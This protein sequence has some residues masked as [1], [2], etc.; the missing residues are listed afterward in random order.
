MPD[1]NEAPLE[2]RSELSRNLTAFDIT[3]VGVGAMIGAGIFVLTGI[4]AGT[5]GPALILAFLLNGIVTTFTAMTYAELGSAIPEAGGGYLWVQKGLSP[6]QA[7]LSGWMSWFAHAV[8][9]SLYALGFGAYFLLLL[10]VFGLG[11]SDFWAETLPKIFAAVVILLFMW[12]NFRGVSETGKAENIVTIGKIVILGIFILSGLLLVAHEPTRMAN[13]QPF[14]PKGFTGVLIAMGLTFIAFEGYEI[15]V[16][17]GEEVKNPKRS[18]PRAIFASLL[19]VLP[20]Y[21]LVSFVGITAV[22]PEAG[23]P[24][25][26]WLANHAELGVAEAARQFMPLGTFLILVGGLLSTVSALNAT[27]FSS[28]RVS[29]AMGRDDNL[30]SFFAQ[31]HRRNRVPHL[32]L[33]ASGALM[34]LMAVSIPIH[35]VAAATDIMF[36]FLF[37]QVNFA[38]VAIRRKWGKQLDYGF[39]TPLFPLVPYIGAASQLLLAV[40]L[41]FY[42]P[43]AWLSAIA[44]VMVGVFIYLGYVERKV[45]LREAAPVLVRETRSGSKVRPQVLVALSNPATAAL[46]SAFAARLARKRETPLLLL[47][48]IQVAPQLPL[49]AGERYL[50]QA[51]KL[52]E[53]G[54]KAAREQG[55]DP[56]LLVRMAHQ[57]TKTILDT[58]EEEQIQDLVIGWH[59]KRGEHTVLGRGIEQ[60]L[61]LAPG[62]VYIFET[63]NWKQP[64]NI[65][66]PLSFPGQAKALL[67]TAALFASDEHK[68]RVKAFHVLA[69][70][71]P[72]ELERER[73]EVYTGLLEQVSSDT[74]E[75]ELVMLRYR[76]LHRIIRRLSQEMDLVVLGTGRQRWYEREVVGRNL[77]NLV[78]R[79]QSP[80]I[81]VR[82][83]DAP[84]LRFVKELRVLI[85]GE[86]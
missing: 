20:I 66:V 6:A 59:G 57:A 84:F 30:P 7:F 23:T 83:K 53:Q 46:L 35:D 86:I 52:L 69:P 51:R 72:A 5:A 85:R 26:Q 80:V 44:W 17:A 33:L 16:Q 31:V 73:S 4:A 3:M 10:H 19:I 27:L 42:S 82:S 70:D 79:I 22:T 76:N 25:W 37:I 65:L 62:N 49:S 34:L 40:F 2:F 55:T 13:L 48:A 68:V 60:L 50:P 38:V 74:V 78:R 14:M 61:A 21:L 12:I 29:F 15:I 39:K 1:K 75:T 41:L 32:A 28:T 81:I 77:E 18:I 47:N 45:H 63:R 67:E 58:L 36:L 43:L 8:A 54:V 56:H 24:T 9:G 71:A 64:R 11:M